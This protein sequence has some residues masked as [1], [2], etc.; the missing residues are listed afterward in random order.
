MGK[1]QMKALRDASARF[2]KEN[3]SL[4]RR[5]AFECS[6]RAEMV[7]NPNLRPYEAMMK[8]WNR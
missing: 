4:Y 1:S 7:K 3:P 2:R 8:V 6:V 5:M